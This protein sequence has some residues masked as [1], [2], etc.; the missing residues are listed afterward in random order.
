MFRSSFL[1]AQIIS[2]GASKLTVMSILAFIV[3]LLAFYF[4]SNIVAKILRKGILYKTSLDPGIKDSIVKITRYV[5]TIIGLFMGFQVLGLN[6]GSLA[7]F[8]GIL[9]LGVGFGLQNVIS[10]FISG[11]IVLIERPIIVGDYI[12]VGGLDGVVTKIRMR[13]TTIT[14]RNNISVIVPN[15]SFITENVINWSHD[16]PKVRIHIPVGIEET[17]SKLDLAREILLQIADGHPDVLKEVAPAVWFET[18]G[19]STFNL[20]LLVWIKSAI[21]RHYIISDINFEIAKRFSEYGIDIA[22]PYT[23]II[24]KNDIRIRNTEGFVGADAG[25]DSK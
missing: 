19:S 17:A 7:V 12:E 21:R 20:T 11:I 4:A 3:V 15:S 8:A 1:N 22:Y 5:I 2:I 10:N 14:T 25:R 18:F 13:S 6:L 24:L 16:D 23:N 9:S